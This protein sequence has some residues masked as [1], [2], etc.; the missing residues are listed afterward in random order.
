MSIFKASKRSRLFLRVWINV[1]FGLSYI[2]IN[3]L[4][5]G[6][7]SGSKRLITFRWPLWNV[8]VFLV[9]FPVFIAVKPLCC[10]GYLCS[11]VWQRDW[12]FLYSLTLRN[13]PSKIRTEADLRTLGKHMFFL[14][15]LHIS[16]NFTASGLGFSVFQWCVYQQIFKRGKKI[17]KS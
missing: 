15:M 3:L 16:F 6:C 7:N 14:C 8:L 13:G 2:Q 17:P 10:C 11:C 9:Q 12:G 1:W 5:S 4:I